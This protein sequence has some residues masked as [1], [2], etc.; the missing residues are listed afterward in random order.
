MDPVLSAILRAATKALPLIGK[1]V[2]KNFS[3]HRAITEANATSISDSANAFI[4][5]LTPSQLAELEIFVN[6]QQ[7][8]HLTRQTFYSSLE[9]F[10]IETDTAIREQ[11]RA[12]LRLS[13]RFDG[14][15][16]LQMTDVL[17]QAMKMTIV[18]LRTSSVAAD[19]DGTVAA[20][21]G[22]NAAAAIRNSALMQRT[23][24]LNE[25]NAFAAKMRGQASALYGRLKLANVVQSRK[26]GYSQL[27]VQPSLAYTDGRAFV[28]TSVEEALNEDLRLVIVGDPGA[29]K[30][31][32]AS[33]LVYDIANDRVQGLEGLVPLLLVVRDHTRHLRTEHETLIHYLD[34]TCR[35]PHNVP[36]PADSIEY[37]L[38]NGRAFVVIDGVDELGDSRF[39]ADFA[40]MVDGFCHLYPL[41]RVAVT[42][43]IV[44]YEDAPLDSE[45]FTV[46]RMAPFND[47]QVSRYSHLWFKLDKNRSAVER[48]ATAGAFLAGSR[49]IRDLRANPL[50]LS[51]LCV[52]F[53]AEHAIPSRRPEIYERCA[54]ILFD[55][56]DRSRGIATPVRYRQQL[57]PVLQRLAW[58]IFSDQSGTLTLPRSSVESA[59]VEWLKP[60]FASEE[61]A[62]EVAQD[63][64]DFCAGR[65]WVLTDVG[66]DVLEPRYGFVHKTFL[67]YFAATQI[68]KDNSD[69]SVV[70]GVLRPNLGN[71]AWS[72]VI[73][74]AAQVLDRNSNEGG[75]RLVRLMINAADH[76]ADES[77]RGRI[78]LTAAQIFDNVAPNFSTIEEVAVR[79]VR[80]SV[81]VPARVRCQP[82]G[83]NRFES[84]VRAVDEPLWDGLLRVTFPDDFD[85]VADVLSK[86]IWEYAENF[87]VESS[88]GLVYAEI[89]FHDNISGSHQS[90][91]D[92]IRNRLSQRSVPPNAELW[93]RMLHRPLPR[94]LVEWGHD[95]LYREFKFGRTTWYSVT[96]RAMLRCLDSTKSIKS[97]DEVWLEELYDFVAA[98]AIGIPDGY[99]PEDSYESYGEDGTIERL[100]ARAR[101]CLLLLMVPL[102]PFLIKFFKADGRLS[103]LAGL[104]EL[105]EDRAASMDY[106]NSLTLPG[107]AHNRLALW[108]ASPG[109]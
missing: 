63:F 82:F 23:G 97:A 74:I 50:M 10:K 26:V 6:S 32:L 35:N 100:S 28:L 9:G 29:G 57:R 107:E 102:F 44:G 33:K 48:K 53:T 19:V 73:Q 60:R 34:A 103:R 108:V 86:A 11:L 105:P 89:A 69:P 4:D 59:L 37:L 54:E 27:Y 61:E 62:A 25:I 22:S 78:L 36:P 96:L 30:S 47:D 93:T 109:S 51:L 106:L 75:D 76:A 14:A 39:R 104:N 94:D 64:L 41:A 77:L 43:R 8:A 24:S 31:T 55:T 65:A 20:M 91:V 7:F 21:T 80:D 90:M 98:N 42:S 1:R 46:T 67:E 38:L 95:W 71:S 84:P 16:L 5:G 79:V 3:V 58:R 85:Q 12:S 2:Q 70:W 101:G 87:S 72:M 18:G 68:V 17:H 92:A 40:R 83:R 56:W 13:G 49:E 81:S 88:A 66:S 15:D 52:L 99:V 45:L